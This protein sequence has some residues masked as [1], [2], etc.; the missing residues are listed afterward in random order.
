MNVN[1][2]I[3]IGVIMVLFLASV[4]LAQETVIAVDGVSKATIVVAQDS[5]VYEKHAAAELADFLGQV[6]GGEFKVEGLGFRGQGS[7]LLVGAKAANLADKDFST[8]GLGQEG[9]IIRTVENDLILAGGQPRGTLYAVYTFLEDAVG[10]RW[11]APGESTIPH[12]TTLEIPALN[13]R[14]VP[15]IEMREP[16]WFVTSDGDWCVRNK[17]NGGRTC[18]DPHQG[19]KFH[20]MG[21]CHS[22]YIDIPPGKYFKD[23][24][25]WFSEI[26]GK[27]TSSNA[28]LCMTNDELIKE[29]T[30]IIKDN[31][32]NKSK[33]AFF[34]YI[35]D[36][37]TEQA[38]AVW[39]SQND[40]GGHCQCEKCKA[41]NDREGTPAGALLQFVNAIAEDVE[42]E[43]PQVAVYTF[44][45]DWSQKPP[46][47]IKPRPNVVIWLC[48]T[49]CKYNVPY[50]H[51]INKTFQ[52]N[53]DVWSKIHDRIYIW[54]YVTN[55]Q[56]YMCPH[57]NIRTLGP[58]VNYFVDHNVRGVFS[59]GAANAPGAE[60]APLR[61]W[62]LAKLFWN[63]S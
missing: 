40:W 55:F 50:T 61:A 39:V 53:I 60:M 17:V 3:K 48:T 8:K 44:A 22:F 52:E 59:Q 56:A 15:I 7:R 42:K 27:R 41:I 33:N 10:C 62:V 14:Y 28:Q 58:N 6:T 26:D 57:P 43:F 54:D 51:E 21:S 35:A 34:N 1:R 46:K 18:I 2:T 31:L 32:R 30:R 38:S 5:P 37:N 13:I 4:G 25:Q 45:Y 12:K 19:S 11:W 47:T 23:H 36:T 63:P 49:G 9:L 29:Y 20:E 24:P 16:Y